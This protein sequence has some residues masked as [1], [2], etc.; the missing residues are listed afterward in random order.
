MRSPS[1]T[2]TRRLSGLGTRFQVVFRFSNLEGPDSTSGLKRFA[3]PHERAL[4]LERCRYG[5]APCSEEEQHCIP[6]PGIHQIEIFM[7][8]VMDSTLC[9]L[10][11]LSKVSHAF[12]RFR[13]SDF[14]ENVP[15]RTIR[16]RTFLNAHLRDYVLKSLDSCA[17]GVFSSQNCS[18]IDLIVVEATT[19]L[20]E[21]DGLREIENVSSHTRQG[22]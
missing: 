14:R 8:Q 1:S 7:R 16:R 17:F 21:M 19:N 11:T 10:I 2:L 12:T 9:L 13:T 15:N 5:R 20:V 22:N 3:P 4:F 18:S 6:N